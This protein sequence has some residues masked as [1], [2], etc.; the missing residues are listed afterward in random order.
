MI[1][2]DNETL[3]LIKQDIDLGNTVFVGG[4]I[5]Q[6]IESK[7]PY[8]N[9]TLALR[10]VREDLKEILSQYPDEFILGQV[11]YSLLEEAIEGLGWEMD[12]GS[13]DFNGWEHDTWFDVLV[14]DRGIGY[15]VFCSWADPRISFKKFIINEEESDNC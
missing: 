2:I 3:N 12:E 7:N 13:F 8:E 15:H 6:Y 9:L 5:A 14:K 4:T 10:S 11:H 1:V